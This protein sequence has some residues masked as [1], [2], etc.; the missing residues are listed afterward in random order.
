MKKLFTFLV[1]LLT[2]FS[3]VSQPIITSA[4]M[5]TTPD[6]IRFRTTNLAAGLNYQ[7]TGMNFTWDFSSLTSSTAGADTFVA[8][9]ATPFVYQ[10]VFAF[11]TNNANMASPQGDF[12]LI[13]GIPLTDILNFH[14]KQTANFTMAGMGAS[15][16]GITIPIKYNAPDVIYKFPVTVGTEDSSS[17][18]FS[19]GIP[20]FGFLDIQ[21]KRHNY[22]DGW[23]TLILPNGSFSAI[24]IKSVITEID[25]IY[26]DT[27]GFGIAIPRNSIE[28]KWLVDG[29]GIPQLQVTEQ[30]GVLTTWK[31]VDETALPN[32]F[33]VTI[34]NDTTICSGQSITLT[35]NASGG[36]PPYTYIWSN[37]SFGQSI[38]VTPTTTTT[39]TIS[40]ADA[41]FALA[42]ASV[43]VNVIV[44]PGFEDSKSPVPVALFPNPASDAVMLVLPASVENLLSIQI[45]DETGKVVKSMESAP[46]SFSVPGS[47][48]L[49]DSHELSPGF[50]GVIIR[51]NKGILT[52]KL[53]IQ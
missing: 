42:T 37:F 52:Q 41:G 35:A 48:Q 33:T 1:S 8:M 3:A 19:A 53:I 13:P 25:S 7:Q 31:W 36:T 28:Y 12:N 6:T 32:L 29:V 4:D 17:V 21:K 24:R 27:L 11:G 9:S 14:K 2:V 15:L 22:V 51:H 50:Y 44:C 47:L 38:T 34:G 10:A 30:F 45:V 40:V 5:P 16:S 39:Y 43:T 23:G 20:G 26:V 46:D 49:L 18:S